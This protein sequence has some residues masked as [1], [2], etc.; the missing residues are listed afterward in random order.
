MIPREIRS[1]RGP[2]RLSVPI[3]ANLLLTLALFAAVGCLDRSSQGTMTPTK[4]TL[5]PMEQTVS[6]TE[7]ATQETRSAPPTVLNTRVPVSPSA[8]PTPAVCS[9]PLKGQI[10]FL[11]A[12]N[13]TNGDAKFGE[14]DEMRLYVLNTDGTG[15]C[16]V[17]G[18]TNI[19][20]FA[21]PP[22]G[23][24]IAIFEGGEENNGLSVLDTESGEKRIL[25]D[26]LAEGF[27]RPVWSPDGQWIGFRGSGYVFHAVL[28]DSQGSQAHHQITLQQ[29]GVSLTD[30]WCWAPNSAELAFAGKNNLGG[31]FG[32][33]RMNRDGSAL[34]L[35]A[36]LQEEWTLGTLRWS[37][38]G[39]RI[40]FTSYHRW[41]EKIEQ[42]DPASGW[43]AATPFELYVIDLDS[44]ETS[45][46]TDI[47][48]HG[49]V[50]WPE[51]SPDGETILYVYRMQE[52]RRDLWLMGADA[53]NPSP[54]VQDPILVFSPH[55]SCAGDLIVFSGL[56]S[57]RL[58]YN[59]E[60]FTV[61]PDGTGL[62]RL[63]GNEF[64]DTFPAW[65]P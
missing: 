45:R 21:V 12:R 41:L 30:P 42:A 63:T 7:I 10:A 44:G 37:S 47:V 51:W 31:N 23:G 48:D 16:R 60:I 8:V 34:T 5:S 62:H 14:S 19:L 39:S 53:S 25:A 35:V 65:L 29:D 20:S 26:N 61:S 13:D 50:W 24:R 2:S 9:F 46:L 56:D 1:K 49:E 32:I 27:V 3:V 6:P 15:E 17:G 11:S 52:D 33:Y 59:N 64:H 55:W 28:V 57:T 22:Q 18:F 43:A 36:E 58:I 38:D 54:L 40:F 4:E